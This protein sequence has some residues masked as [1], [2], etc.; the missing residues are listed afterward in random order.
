[1]SH[2]CIPLTQSHRHNCSHNTKRTCTLVSTHDQKASL[3]FNSH[4]EYAYA[5]VFIEVSFSLVR[6]QASGSAPKLTIFPVSYTPG[7][8]IKIKWR[9]RAPWFTSSSVVLSPVRFSIFYRLATRTQI[10]KLYRTTPLQTSLF[11]IT[12]SLSLR[13]PI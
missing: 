9:L 4:D 3:V 13:L 5:L 11:F 12:P 2:C 8:A 1:M 7:V 10:E 6:A